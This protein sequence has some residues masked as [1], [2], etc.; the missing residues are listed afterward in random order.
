MQQIVRSPSSDAFPPPF[1]TELF[2]WGRV[3]YRFWRI[4]SNAE[5]ELER[6]VHEGKTIEG[7]QVYRTWRRWLAIGHAV[8]HNGSKVED[9]PVNEHSPGCSWFSI[10]R[11]V[12]VWQLTLLERDG[13]LYQLYDVVDLRWTSGVEE[14]I[15][16]YRSDPSTVL[17]DFVVDPPHDCITPESCIAIYRRISNG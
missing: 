2:Q 5:P 12:T 9:W 1:E 11:P 15:A 6:M 16:D 8:D 13:E 17:S 7:H 14:T 3:Q 4:L 10:F